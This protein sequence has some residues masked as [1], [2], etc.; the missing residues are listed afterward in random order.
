MSTNKFGPKKAAA[1]TEVKEIFVGPDTKKLTAEL[2]ARLHQQLKLAAVTEGRPMRAI[3]E[4]ALE[5]YF[6]Q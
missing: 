5:A 3:L 2:D 1:R 6:K 4:E